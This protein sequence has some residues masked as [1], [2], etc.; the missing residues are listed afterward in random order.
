M[1][2][3]IDNFYM[4]G[5]YHMF[6]N[7]FYFHIIIDCSDL[8]FKLDVKEK[9]IVEQYK[10]DIMIALIDRF[11]RMNGG[12]RR[13]MVCSVKKSNRLT[14]YTSLDTHVST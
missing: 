8:I 7:H 11:W 13:V 14:T 5:G 1:N 2:Y 9:N 6:L 12:W 3:K 4:Y 10:C